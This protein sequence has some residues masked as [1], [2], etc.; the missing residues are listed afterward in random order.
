VRGS[1]VTRLLT[2]HF[3]RRF[4]E[5]DLISPHID[6]HENALTAGA[7]I[8]SLSLFLSVMLGAKYFASLP[9]PGIIAVEALGDNFAFINIAMFAM[10]LVATLQWEALSLDVR[11]VSNLGLLPVRRRDLVGAKLSAL[12]IFAVGFALALIAFESTIYQVLVIVRMPLGLS[13][14][15]R[16][17]TAHAVASALACA[18]AFLTV[19]AIREGSRIVL[20]GTWFGRAS[21]IVQATLVLVFTTGLLISP[22]LADRAKNRWMREGFPEVLTFPPLAF[23]ALEQAIGNGV[24]ANATGVMVPNRMVD[25]NARRLAQ[26]RAQQPYF[27]DGAS[28]ALLLTA[29]MLVVAASAYA[30][31]L[32][33]LPQPAIAPSRRRSLVS[34]V[35]AVAAARDPMRRAGLSFALQAI[36]R[37][38]PHRIAMAGALALTTALSVGMLARTGFREALNPWYPPASILAVQT[39][40]LTLLIAGFRRAVRVP[41]ELRAN[42]IMQLTW[43]RGERRFLAGVKLAA[44]LGVALPA[45]VALVPLHLWLLSPDVAAVHFVLGLCYALVLSEAL[46]TGCKKVPLASSYEPLSHVKTLGP[47]V[48][49]LFLIF[50]N[51]FARVERDAFQSTQ[52][53]VNFVIVSLVLIAT[54]RVVDYWINRDGK[55]LKFDE[56]PEPATQWLGLSH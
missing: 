47:I 34:A 6:L 12:T 56:P 3:L 17:A 25:A 28:I 53:I 26:Y 41:A 15:V 52:G 22:G 30:W 32:R 16:L 44:I 51:T 19:V 14:F 8:V 55:T 50:L 48:F 31:N 33:Q 27:R 42:W 37:S 23:M 11:D 39:I 13:A 43:K 4:F 7:A 49:V 5:N 45:L 1:P 18:F 21:A 46:F 35:G 24:V 29:G 9:M 2:R 10:A 20:G 54:L 38:G 36:V 40:A